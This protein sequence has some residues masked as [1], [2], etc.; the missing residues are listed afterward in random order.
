VRSS[1]GTHNDLDRILCTLAGE[2]FGQCR[3]VQKALESR[4]RGL[5]DR[6]A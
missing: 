3:T 1:V 2:D 6:A 4:F 5:A